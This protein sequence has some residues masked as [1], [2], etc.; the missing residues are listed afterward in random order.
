MTTL[1]EKLTALRERK[2]WTKTF[3]ARKLGIKTLSTYANYE[4][5]TREPDMETLSRIADIY[6]ISLDELTGR[7][8]D[9]KH[10]I[11]GEEVDTSDLS[12]NQRLVL[13]WAMQQEALSFHSTEELKEMLD[14]MA[15]IFE[16]ERRKKNNKSK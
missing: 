10:T 2:G 14:N 1:G 6:D 5:G 8:V 11:R 16:Y 15:V 13:E 4:Y 9:S 3:V 7:S 12:E